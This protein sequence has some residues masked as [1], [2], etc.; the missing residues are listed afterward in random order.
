[1]YMEGCSSYLL[2]E[3]LKPLSNDD[4]GAL[5]RHVTADEIKEAIFNIGNEKAPSP[6]G[7]NALFFQI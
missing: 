4:S 7:Y 1:M 5:C 6:D 2:R 3:L